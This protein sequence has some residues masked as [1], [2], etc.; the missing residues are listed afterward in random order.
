MTADECIDLIAASIN[1]AHSQ[2]KGVI[3]GVYVGVLHSYII[4]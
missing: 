4:K 1:Y 3:T 2:V